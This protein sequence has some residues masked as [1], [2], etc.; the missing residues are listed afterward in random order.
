MHPATE[1]KWVF[2][3]I[4]LEELLNELNIDPFY[5]LTVPK[6]FHNGMQEKIMKI[7]NKVME[8]EQNTTQEA[9]TEAQSREDSCNLSAVR[10]CTEEMDL[11]E[12]PEE[13]VETIQ[14]HPEEER[15][16]VER[17]LRRLVSQ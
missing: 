11:T 5:L 9:S 14:G 13:K 4:I 10:D 3:N 17:K 6:S 15:E 12:A 16:N 7:F 1:D 2:Y 8:N